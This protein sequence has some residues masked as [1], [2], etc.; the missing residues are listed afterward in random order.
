MKPYDACVTKIMV[1]GKKHTV[2][3]NVDGLKSIHVDTKI[4]DYFH[5]WLDKTYGSDNIGHV[6]ASRGKVKEYLAMTLYCTQ[7]VKLKIDM[8][9]YLDEMISKF[10]HKSSDKMNC[11]WTDKM[12]KLDEEENNM[13]KKRGQYFICL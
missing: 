8:R 3:W 6:G 2:A 11:P 13:E 4:N 12:F 1:N 5:K 7:E 10:P 9:K